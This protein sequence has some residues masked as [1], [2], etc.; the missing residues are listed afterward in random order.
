MGGGRVLAL[1]TSTGSA[2]VEIGV[3]SY[4]CCHGSIGWGFLIIILV[5]ALRLGK[6][7]GAYILLL[8]IVTM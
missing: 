7:L 3:G 2:G 4:A 6:L 5:A 1:V 8:L